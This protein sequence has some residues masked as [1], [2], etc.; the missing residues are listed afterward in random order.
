MTYQQ[1]IIFI[2][3]RYTSK[4]L[5]IL[6][7]L[8]ILQ[9]THSLQTDLCNGFARNWTST[10][11]LD[12]GYSSSTNICL[13]FAATVEKMVILAKSLHYTATVV[14][15]GKSL[16]HRTKSISYIFYLCMCII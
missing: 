2:W 11:T 4:Y 7:I 9:S 8:G 1:E 14:N 6:W 15:G 16:R 13:P 3:T 5:T 12:E 10:D